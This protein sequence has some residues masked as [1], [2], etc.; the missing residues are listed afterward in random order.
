MTSLKNT[1]LPLTSEH[2]VSVACVRDCPFLDVIQDA[3][4]EAKVSFY[5]DEYQA[6]ASVMNGDTNIILGTISPAV[7]VSPDIF[8][9]HW[10][11]RTTLINKSN[12]IILW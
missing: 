6:M 12:I 9:N 3:F 7:I 4:P 10:L 8:R 2:Q 5:D 11:L 1:M